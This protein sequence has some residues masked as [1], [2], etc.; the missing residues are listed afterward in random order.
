M[1]SWPH[2]VKLLRTRPLK[3]HSD[4]DIRVRCNHQGRFV[5]PPRLSG[6]ETHWQSY[7]PISSVRG[8]GIRQLALYLNGKVSLLVICKGKVL[9]TAK[10][11]NGFSN[12]SILV[13]IEKIYQT[14]K[15]VIYHISKQLKICQKYYTG[16]RIFNYTVLWKYNETLSQVFDNYVLSKRFE[17]AG[18]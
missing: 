10:L 4:N 18:E 5:R 12:S 14:L 1:I 6:R 2:N 16:S 7:I 13:L 9:L 8:R 15:I 17:V 3:L 11:D